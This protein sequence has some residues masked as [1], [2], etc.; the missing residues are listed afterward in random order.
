MKLDWEYLL[1]IGSDDLVKDGLIELYEPL[2]GKADY[3][4]TKDAVIINSETGECRRLTSDTCY[5]LGRCFSRKLIKEVCY[6]VEIL[7]LEGIMTRGRTTAKGKTGFFKIPMAKELE[8]LG[9][10]EIKSE[11][12]YRLWKD[13][14][15]RG[16]DNNSDFFLMTQG[17]GH[18]TVKTDKPLTIDIKGPDNIWK[19]SDRIGTP[20]DI[21]Q[22]LEG[23]SEEEQI[24]L[25]AM[26]KRNKKLIEYA[27]PI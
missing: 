19:F 2:F 27:D 14:I 7:A 12:R 16:L 11:P 23:L 17:I 6:G 9:R 24:A 15:T 8:S 3:F 4:G 5:G 18:R 20:Y 13:D 25:F 21:N 1:E 26:I 10:V 22:A